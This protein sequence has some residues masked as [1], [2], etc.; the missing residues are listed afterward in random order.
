[1]SARAATGC[2]DVAA[3]NPIAVLTGAVITPG[4]NF[5]A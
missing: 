3:V 4:N 2:F 5:S 1:M